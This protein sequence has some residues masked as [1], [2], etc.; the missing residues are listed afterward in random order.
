MSTYPSN[1]PPGLFITVPAAI[2]TDSGNEIP[3]RGAPFVSPLS[4]IPCGV[5]DRSRKGFF[6]AEDPHP[7]E[8]SN[9]SRVQAATD[10]SVVSPQTLYT[11]SERRP[12]GQEVFHAIL[13]NARLLVH[14]PATGEPGAR[15]G[16]ASVQLYAAP[17]TDKVWDLEVP[18][19]SDQQI[20]EEL[21]KYGPGVHREVQHDT[22]YSE[23]ESSVSDGSPIGKASLMSRV[24][25]PILTKTNVSVFSTKA[26]EFSYVTHPADVPPPFDTSQMLALGTTAEGDRVLRVPA[27]EPGGEPVR[28][29]DTPHLPWRLLENP[30]ALTSSRVSPQDSPMITDR[31][32]ESPESMPDLELHQPAPV[33]CR[34][35]V[36][37]ALERLDYDAQRCLLEAATE[38]PAPKLV[39]SAFTPVDSH[40][41]CTA[42]SPDDDDDDISSSSE[43]REEEERDRDPRHGSRADAIPIP[44]HR[45]GLVVTRSHYSSSPSAVLSESTVDHPVFDR[46][47]FQG[48]PLTAWE[49]CAEAERIITAAVQRVGLGQNPA[50]R[51]SIPSIFHFEPEEPS[52]ISSNSTD[53]STDLPDS[54]SFAADGSILVRT[55]DCLDAMARMRRSVPSPDMERH[56]TGAYNT[57]LYEWNRQREAHQDMVRNFE[58]IDMLRPLRKAIMMIQ[59]KLG[60]VLD[61]A[62]MGQAGTDN[63]SFLTNYRYLSLATVDASVISALTPLAAIRRG[64]QAFFAEVVS[65]HAYF[66]YFI[67]VQALLVDF[68]ERA[69]RIITRRRWV[70]DFGLLQYNDNVPVPLLSW[71]ENVK[72]R[73]FG[74]AFAAHGQTAVTDDVDILLGY[75]F[76]DA[77]VIAHFLEADLLGEED[78]GEMPD[79]CMVVADTAHSAGGI[80]D[81]ASFY[82]RYPGLGTNLAAP[83]AVASNGRA[84]V[85]HVAPAAE[86]GRSLR[87]R[88]PV[89]R[90]KSNSRARRGGTNTAPERRG[91]APTSSRRFNYN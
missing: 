77:H 28:R 30:P 90:G 56:N 70:L 42:S 37:R 71:E 72:F 12:N 25:P 51:S 57:R 80:W 14:D 64:V 82:R 63:A 36:E 53:D 69:E 78:E 35:T 43:E 8:G 27:R 91:N 38:L 88:T 5:L 32:V 19:V 10:G 85:V 83:Q 54:N 67:A 2:T 60:D 33:P 48:K 15:N 20:Q 46:Q 68:L 18:Y 9:L 58:N 76:R 23:D 11:G 22:S 81:R 24:T 74:A 73:L 65:R 41:R 75:H 86:R 29:P 39:L 59:E 21:T 62:A 16:H 66:I 89:R 61:Y 1:S 44:T 50:Q 6:G 87:I 13:L 34:D 55:Q 3:D 79:G 4:P 84:K 26:G 31:I 45:H 47:L 17:N 49:R 40:L 52:P 7:R